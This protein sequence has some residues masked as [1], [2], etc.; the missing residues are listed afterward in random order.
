MKSIVHIGQ[1]SRAI[2]P[3]YDDIKNKKVITE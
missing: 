1:N 3:I 2:G